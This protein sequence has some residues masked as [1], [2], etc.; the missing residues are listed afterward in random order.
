MP[1]ELLVLGVGLASSDEYMILETC[2][3][4]SRIKGI[5][6]SWDQPVTAAGGTYQLCWCASS[7][8]SCNLAN[9][10]AL[11][12]GQVDV[13][14]PVPL[15]QDQTCAAGQVCKLDGLLGV[16]F[17]SDDRILVLD[18]CGALSFTRGFPSFNLTTHVDNSSDGDAWISHAV[19]WG[20]SALTAPAGD[21]RLCWC[22][23]T[24]DSVSSAQHQLSS[25][26]E[27]TCSS[28][29][30]A[31]GNFTGDQDR[32]V[33]GTLCT[34]NFPVDMGTLRVQ[35]VSFHQDRTCI[36][37]Q[38][39]R[40]GEILGVMHENSAVM[41]LD[42][43]GTDIAIPRWAW[44]ASASGAGAYGVEF[45]WGAEA[46]TAASGQYRLC[47]CAAAS[48]ACSTPRDFVL[49]FGALSLLGP[50]SDH[51]IVRTCVSGERC[52]L[53]EME[54]QDLEGSEL[55]IL[56]TCGVASQVL[57]L[58]A[59]SFDL[60]ANGSLGSIGLGSIT[61]AGGEYRICWCGSMG[62]SVTNSCQDAEHFRIDVGTLM[63]LG[64]ALQQDRTCVSGQTCSMYITGRAFLWATLAC[65]SGV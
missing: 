52:R 15:E 1:C 38:T 50:I 16:G 34:Q 40:I 44:V 43:C 24:K 30:S 35:G 65:V 46:V 25:Q 59:L 21:Y 53:P 7:F 48:Y 56:D 8:F 57:H 32:C 20:L 45:H 31:F 37:G 3:I 14:G 62:V 42:T 10:F 4:N 27:A 17:S 36:S 5:P 13:I 51:R 11:P 6:N 28:T 60:G 64:P 58:P 2:G 18:S 47:W 41:A 12:F 22:S 49:D 9:E 63:L 39:C 54:S 19:S 33:L 23:G 26:R 55:V 61:A 29:S